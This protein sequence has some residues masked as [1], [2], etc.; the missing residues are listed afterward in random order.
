MGEE[1]YC[2]LNGKSFSGLTDAEPQACFDA[3]CFCQ[4]CPLCSTEHHYYLNFSEQ[5]NES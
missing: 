5:E 1:L 2:E 4:S 3:D